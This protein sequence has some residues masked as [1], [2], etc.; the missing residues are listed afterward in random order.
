MIK[1]DEPQLREE[2]H[3]RAWR[4]AYDGAIRIRAARGVDSVALALSME[5]GWENSSLH[6]LVRSFFVS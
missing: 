5:V 4:A 3:E 1:R 6:T 2:V